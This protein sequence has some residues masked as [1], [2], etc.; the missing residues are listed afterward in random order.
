M[1]CAR[2]GKRKKGRHCRVPECRSFYRI[3]ALNR[4]QGPGFK[5][6]EDSRPG[7]AGRE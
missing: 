2:C 3:L 7:A 4:M 5:E 1:K 6:P